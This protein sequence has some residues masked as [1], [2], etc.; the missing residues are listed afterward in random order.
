MRINTNLH[1]NSKKE[2]ENT[3]VPQKMYAVTMDLQQTQ[4]LP[5][6]TTSKAFYLRKLWFYN[7]SIHSITSAREKP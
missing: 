2:I 3:L 6:I 1:L 7:V 5:K 4:A